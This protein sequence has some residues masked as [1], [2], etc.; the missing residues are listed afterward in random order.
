VIGAAHA[1][2]RGALSGVI[3]ATV[4]AMERLGAER[5][6]IRAALG[7]MIRKPITRSAPI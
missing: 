5:G 2:W 6:Q 3:E 1:G 4:E 7:P